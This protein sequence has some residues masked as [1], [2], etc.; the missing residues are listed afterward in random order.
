LLKAI[1]SGRCDQKPQLPRY[2]PKE[3]YFPL[4][5]QERERCPRLIRIWADSGFH[6]EDFMRSV[7]DTFGWVLEV[8]SRPKDCKGF[9]L[10]PKRWTVERTYGWL[11]WCRRL[12]LDYERLPISSE[13]LIY[14]VM[15]RLMLHRLA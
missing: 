12:N 10:L 6:G 3:G 2:L 14:I 13:S 11:H 1:S 4:V 15:S 7:M 5:H 9:V 8:V